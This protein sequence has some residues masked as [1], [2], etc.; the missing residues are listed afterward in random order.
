MIQKQGQKVLNNILRKF[1]IC[2]CLIDS[3]KQFM[4]YYNLLILILTLQCRKG[5]LLSLISILIAKIAGV[6][7]TKRNEKKLGRTS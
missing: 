1:I 7:T 6:I 5:H 4:K 2:N 3:I